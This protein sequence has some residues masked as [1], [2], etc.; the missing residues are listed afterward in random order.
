V[1]ASAALLGGLGLGACFA[2]AAAIGGGAAAGGYLVSW[3]G[4]LPT[5]ATMV[6]VVAV[7]VPVAAALRRAARQAVA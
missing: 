4:Q 1:P 2:A 3:F 5:G 7:A 6:V